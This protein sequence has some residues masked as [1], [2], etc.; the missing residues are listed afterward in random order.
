[1]AEREKGLPVNYQGAT[2]EEVARAVLQYRPGKKKQAGRD[3]ET[4][5]R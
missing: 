1:M 3:R 4:D 2:P 5:K